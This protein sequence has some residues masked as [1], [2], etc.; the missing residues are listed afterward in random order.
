MPTRS[1]P[2]RHAFLSAWRLI[3]W[4]AIV[5]LVGAALFAPATALANDLHQSGPISSTEGDF[6]GS[7]GECSEVD[8]EAGTVLWHFVQNQVDKSVE[9]ASLTAQF[10]TAGTLTVESYKKA[11]GTLHFAIV[12]EADVLMEATSTV[13]SDGQLKSQPHLPGRR[14]SGNPGADQSPTPTD[15]SAPSPTPTPTESP[16]PSPTP[17][18]TK[19]PTPTRRP[20]RPNPPHR[21]RRPRRPTRQGRPAWSWS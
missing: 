4:L 6:Q 14:D 10:E 3:A 15:T 2:S 9:T 8:L 11:G 1:S 20:R 21:A 5:S 17:T 16:T 13:T 19:S 18:P 12:T 7:D